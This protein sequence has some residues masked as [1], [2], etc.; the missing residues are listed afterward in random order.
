VSR[1]AR[2]G[3]PLAVGFVDV[4]HL[5]AVNDSLGHAAGDR[6][7]RNVAN[8]LSS[9]LRPYDTVIRY[10]GDEFVCVMG[11]LTAAGARER[12]STAN[13]ALGAMTE[14][15]SFTAGVSEWAAGDSAT[16][17]VRRADQSLYEERQRPTD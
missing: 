8:A 1:A 6:L 3:E 11:G 9:R 15:G 13:A 12:L 5:K 10:G 16:E 14:D 7:L 2:S 17:L 4:D